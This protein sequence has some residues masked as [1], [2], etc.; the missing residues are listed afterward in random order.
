VVDDCVAPGQTTSQP[1]NTY[2]RARGVSPLRIEWI[3]ERPEWLPW[4][5]ARAY[6]SGPVDRPAGIALEQRV[7][8]H[9]TVFYGAPVPDGFR[10]AADEAS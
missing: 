8:L 10:I 2:A 9:N 4:V 6:L 7:T 3:H 5:M 1:E